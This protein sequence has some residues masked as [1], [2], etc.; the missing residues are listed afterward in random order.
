MIYGDENLHQ[1]NG[2]MELILL[3]DDSD[4]LAAA[5]RY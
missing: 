1:S 2:A 3:K 5:C 4:Y